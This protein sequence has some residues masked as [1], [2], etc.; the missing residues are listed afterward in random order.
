[1]GYVGHERVFNLDKTR[2]YWHNYEKENH[3]FVTK[4]S[5]CLKDKKQHQELRAPLVNIVT[6][7]LFELKSICYLHLDKSKGDYEY[8]LI[9]VDHFTK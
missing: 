1:M 4:D 7:E 3:D 9:V 8:I 5:S 2:F 6:Q